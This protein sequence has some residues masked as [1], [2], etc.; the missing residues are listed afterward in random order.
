MSEMEI[1]CAICGRTNKAHPKR[2][3][4]FVDLSELEKGGAKW[5]PAHSKCLY[6]RRV[7]FVAF[8]HLLDHKRMVLANIRLMKEFP[9]VF[10]HSDWV[11]HLERMLVFIDA[12]KQ[13]GG[14][15][16]DDSFAA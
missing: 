5:Q 3:G 7:V 15:K 13:E 8:R 16:N 12:H 10:T 9:K 14:E 11:T 1:T 4:L 2:I 6:R